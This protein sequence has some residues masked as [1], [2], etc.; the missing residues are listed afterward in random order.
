MLSPHRQDSFFLCGGQKSETLSVLFLQEI[1]FREEAFPDYMKHHCTYCSPN[2][3]SWN[4]VV[5]II[6][7]II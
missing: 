7:M 3:F 4:V 6:I 2:V 5:A 1:P